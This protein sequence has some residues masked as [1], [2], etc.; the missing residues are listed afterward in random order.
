MLVDVAAMRH[1]RSTIAVD[2]DGAWTSRGRLETMS[3]TIHLWTHLERPDTE[4]LNRHVASACGRF[5]DLRTVVWKLDWMRG[6]RDLDELDPHQWMYFAGSDIASFL[7]DVTAVCD[8]LG[9]ALCVASPH[10]GKLPRSFGELRRFVAQRGDAA[11]AQL[12]ARAAAI[13]ATAQWF[14]RIGPLRNAIVH[15]D[16]SKIVFPREPGIAFQ[17]R[18]DYKL[19]LDEPSLLGSNNIARFE[20]FAA[21]VTGRL[22]VLSDDIAGYVLSSFPAEEVRDSW[23]RHPGLGVL[24]LWTDEFLPIA[25]P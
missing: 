10:T 24:A 1:H 22:R 19:L 15:E 21:A 5:A 3:A 23:S 25:E 8:H 14:S 17:L 4:E 12:G 13:V 2:Q 18:N 7:T 9:R 6:L 16:I 20:R 11:S